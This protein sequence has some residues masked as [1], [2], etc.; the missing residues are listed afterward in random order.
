MMVLEMSPVGTRMTTSERNVCA[1]RLGKLQWSIKIKAVWN[2]FWENNDK[3]G[4]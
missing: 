4:M 1:D 3:S 2:L